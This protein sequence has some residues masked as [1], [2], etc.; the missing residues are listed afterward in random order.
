MVWRGGLSG[1][2]GDDIGKVNTPSRKQL[3]QLSSILLLPGSLVF[4]G[5]PYL[6]DLLPLLVTE[7]ECH[8]SSGCESSEI[9]EHI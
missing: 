3:L 6:K 5:P 8:P 9:Q 1:V 2:E 7:R 4:K